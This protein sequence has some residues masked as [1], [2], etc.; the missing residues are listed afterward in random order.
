MALSSSGN[1]LYNRIKLSAMAQATLATQP[2]VSVVTPFYNTAPYLAQCI[3]SVLAQSYS[4]FEYVLVDNCSTDG[5]TEIAASYARADPRI[6][7]IRCTQLL[8][9]IPNYN[10]ALAQ[11]S[12]ESKYS[13][14]VE[15]DNHIFPDCLHQLVQAFEQS[16]SIGLVSSYSLKGDMLYG[17]G[18]PYPLTVVS[19]REWAAQHLLGT[20]VFGSPTQV[21]YRSAMVRQQQ[22]FFDESVLHADTDKCLKILEHWDFGFVHQVLSFT[23]T[24]NDSISSAVRELQDGALDRYLT[25]RRYAS[26]FL[27]GEETLLRRKA[28]RRYYRNL[29]RTALRTRGA[30]S[31]F[32]SFHKA[33]LKTLDEKLDW[34]YLALTMFGEL[35]WLASN[36]GMTTVQAVRYLR[37]R[38]R[39][40]DAAQSCGSDR[41]DLV[42]Q[43]AKPS[44][45]DLVAEASSAQDQRLTSKPE[46]HREAATVSDLREAAL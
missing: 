6:R 45:G 13:K 43:A 22:P 21:M 28:K 30:G 17:S 31:A 39:L 34:P 36:P 7:L 37:R 19:G 3:E 42:P 46:A 16:E 10:R 20:H 33:G 1:S 41:D 38:R 35:L 26:I 40:R 18:Y 44:V 27:K 12:N 32:W 8:E 24:D 23:R 15:A 4:R 14:I 9:Q 25:E 2:L 29:V 11:I 5:A